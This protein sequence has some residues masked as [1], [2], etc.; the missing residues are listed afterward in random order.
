[1]KHV[2]HCKPLV[3]HHET[4]LKHH[5]TVVIQC[6]DISAWCGDVCV[7]GSD[8]GDRVEVIRSDAIGARCGDVVTRSGDVGNHVELPTIWRWDICDCGVGITPQMC[9]RVTNHGDMST[10]SKPAWKQY[11]FQP[12]LVTRW[13][14][15]STGRAC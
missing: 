1:M 2:K 6:N 7:W 8:V 15:H 5:E 13:S 14:T 9:D 3:K 10:F 11:F 12:A 4:L